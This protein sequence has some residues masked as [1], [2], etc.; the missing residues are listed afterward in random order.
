MSRYSDDDY[1]PEYPNAGYLWQ[2][3]IELA[4][5]GRR[6]KKA[7]ADLKAALEALPEKRL[8]EGALC[9]VGG[10]RAGKYGLPEDL[11]A[12]GPGVCAMGAYLWHQ[13]VKAGMDPAAAFESLP[14]LDDESSS[15]HET[16]DAGVAA[17]LVYSLAWEIAYTND[18]RFGSLSPEERYERF[19]RWIDEQLSLPLPTKPPPKP[20]RQPQGPHRSTPF[21]P[22]NSGQVSLV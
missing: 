20:K 18:E 22:L 11:I 14:T 3:R 10:D 7:L 12:Q 1:D 5:A 13:K 16:A 2:K 17:G 8:I 15:I 21:V 6:G 4:L 9:T 19:V